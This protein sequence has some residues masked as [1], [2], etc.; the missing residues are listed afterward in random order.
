VRG[1]TIGVVGWSQLIDVIYLLLMGSV[2]LWIASRRLGRM[3][4]K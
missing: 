3:L 1:L 4:L 2:F